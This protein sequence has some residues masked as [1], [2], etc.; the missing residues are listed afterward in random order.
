M[1][2]DPTKLQEVRDEWKFAIEAQNS[3]RTIIEYYESQTGGTWF[4]DFQNKVHGLVLSFAFSVLQ[5]TLEILRAEG[6][7]KC[8][9]KNPPLG[10][11]M[12][13][14]NG[15]HSKMKWLDFL[16][17]DE[18]RE[19]R[20]DLVHHQKVLRREDTWKYIAAIENELVEW[21]VLTGPAERWGYR[22]DRGP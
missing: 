16:V 11:L 17:V 3:M 7:F 8:G 12:N 18:G 20:N 15:K 1:I 2:K 22:G 10:N 5:H 4:N 13:A 9:R 6:A 21:K 19:K 14:S